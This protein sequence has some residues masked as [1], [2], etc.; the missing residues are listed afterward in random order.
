VAQLAQ[1]VTVGSVVA[2]M[3]ARF[4]AGTGELSETVRQQQDAQEAWRRVDATLIKDAAGRDLA[5]EDELRAER[6]ALSVKVRDFDTQ[7]H[8][9]FPAYADATSQDP[10]SLAAVQKLLRVD[11][12]M[13]SY[14][15]SPTA[16][17]AWVVRPDGAELVRLAIGAAQLDQVVHLLRRGLDPTLIPA[18][19]R[20]RLPV[21]DAKLAFELQK[22]IF[23]P[24]VPALH[25]ARHVLVVPDGP[26]QALPPSVLVG[27][28][29]PAVLAEPG[30]YRK[31]DWLVRHYAFA[32]LPSVNSLRALRTFAKP[33]TAKE[34]FLGFGNPKLGGPR[35]R[36]HVQPAMR[37]E[38]IDVGLV[39]QLNPLPETAD[40][41]DAIA[42]T[43]KAPTDDVMLGVQATRPHLRA[44]D[45]ADY[46]VVAFATHGLMAGELKGLTEPALVLTPNA[47]DDPDD[48]LLRASEIAQLHFDAD[49][50]VLSACN[51]AA[52]D[53][54]STTESLSG[55]ARAFFYAGSR[56][57][58]VSHW[59]VNSGASVQLTTAAVELAV[60]NPKLGKAEALER[61]MVKLMDG[62][63]P[64]YA[65]PMM[66][67]PF[68]VVG[69][70][71][72][73]G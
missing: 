30:D 25:G 54:G 13:V 48:G 3:A 52:A 2:K 38:A 43:L 29:P 68:V 63:D 21:Y 73:G 12:V 69:E 39:N 44:L 34:P 51:T 47:G 55:L 7:L 58:L 31:V 6:A 66:W 60:D 4:A 17:Y 57:I 62:S 36:N 22:K 59:P 23:A 46:R 40:E 24:I 9:R 15:V 20:D 19:A 37:G 11:E 26:L 64:F 41:L 1:G 56:S 27:S 72:V 71:G 53:G 49:W 61:S 50:V 70:G 14:L 45:L 5:A 28:E 42:R 8:A 35:L 67:A 16:S 18:D 33:S 32:I 65:H 10:E